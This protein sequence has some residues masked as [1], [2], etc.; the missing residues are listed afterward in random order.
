MVEDQPHKEKIMLFMT[1]HA[2]ILYRLY[3][4]I[5]CKASIFL[6]IS[7]MIKYLVIIP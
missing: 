5:G 3:N 1:I 6:M 7:Q 4:C 2:Q